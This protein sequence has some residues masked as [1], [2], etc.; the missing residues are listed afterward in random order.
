MGETIHYAHPNRKI[1][2]MGVSMIDG[3]RF[4]C[5]NAI[6]CGVMI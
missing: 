1:E 2:E 5:T 6:I 4:V 3:P